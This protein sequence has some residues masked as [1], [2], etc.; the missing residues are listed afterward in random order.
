MAV[1]LRGMRSR[2][3]RPAV[4]GFSRLVLTETVGSYLDL[5][6]GNRAFRSSLRPMSNAVR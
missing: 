2:V 3:G 6:Q 5:S 4:A 1:V